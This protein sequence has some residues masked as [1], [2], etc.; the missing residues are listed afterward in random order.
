MHEAISEVIIRLCDQNLLV[1]LMYTCN[2][3]KFA[4]HLF[5]QRALPIFMSYI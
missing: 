3:L 4:P 1:Q 2:E 5:A